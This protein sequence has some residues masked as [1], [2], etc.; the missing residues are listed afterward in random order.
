MGNVRNVLEYLE[1][2]AEEYPDKLAYAGSSGSYSFKEIMAVSRSVGTYLAGVVEK[3]S[4]V[5]VYME[6]SA[7]QIAAF[8]GTAYAGAFYAPIDVK[9]PPQRVKLILDTLEAGCMIVDAKSAGRAEELGFAGRIINFDDI[10]G[11]E[12][13][14]PRLEQIRRASIDSDPLYAIFTSGSTGV[15]K[16]VLISQRSAVNFTEWYCNAFSHDNET[17]FGNQTPF[18]FDASVKQI[19]ATIRCGATMYIIPRMLFSFP[20]KLIEYLNDHK[21]NCIDW[22]PSALCIITKFNT[23][24]KI[25]PKYLKK[26]IF[27]ADVMPTKQY[28]IWKKALPDVMYGN[29]YGPTEI[30]VDCCYYIVDRELKDS[31]PIPIGRAC[32]NTDVMILNEKNELVKQ[33][34]IGELCV[35]G[36]SL[37]LGYYNNQEKTDSVFVQNPLQKHYRELMYRT[38]DLAKYNEYGEIIYVARKDFQIKHMGHRIELGEIETALG[39]VEGIQ[40]ACCLYEK[41]SEKIIAVYEGEATRADIINSVKTALPKYMIPNVYHQLDQIPLNMNGKIDRVALTKEFVR[42]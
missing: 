32:E 18:Y 42:E 3:G 22:V 24:E 17:V 4:P 21:I 33:G 25:M 6:K 13:D 37:A 23:F 16:G 35:R 27:G 39:A 30:T 9:M 40:R 26:V 41:S 5:A 29:T 8:F 2:S 15:P 31:E 11:T 14:L 28:N 7:Q 10:S 1:R 19:Y 38:G 20:I 34:E 36:V 12:A